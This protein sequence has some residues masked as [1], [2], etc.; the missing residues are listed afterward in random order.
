MKSR[1]EYW[2]RYH[3]RNRKRRNARQR[4]YLDLCYAFGINPRKPRGERA[5]RP[6]HPSWKDMLFDY[7]NGAPRK[8]ILYCY[9]YKS[10]GN[11]AR[12]LKNYGLPRRPRGAFVHRLEWIAYH[13][14]RVEE[15]IARVGEQMTQ[16]EARRKAWETRLRREATVLAARRLRPPGKGAECRARS[17]RRH[18]HEECRSLALAERE[19]ETENSS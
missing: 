8:W 1:K 10:D 5:M 11:V 15:Y 3:R 18:V 12:F 4:R 16:A 6:R 19:H 9:G 14:P 7:Y 2:R 13:A 17:V